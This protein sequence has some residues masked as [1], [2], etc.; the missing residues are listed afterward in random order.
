LARRQLRIS[1]RIQKRRHT[2]DQFR[3]LRKLERRSMNRLE[4]IIDHKRSRSD[5]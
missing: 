5:E 3:S 2:S 1:R 4:R